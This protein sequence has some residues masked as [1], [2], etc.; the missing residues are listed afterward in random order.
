MASVPEGLPQ[1][2]LI[3]AA[4]LAEYLRIPV[5]QVYQL[6]RDGILPYSKWGRAIRFN[7]VVIAALERKGGAAFAHGWRKQ[8]RQ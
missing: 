2:Q 8:A 1:S 4:Q 7:L 5:R 6:K 3:T